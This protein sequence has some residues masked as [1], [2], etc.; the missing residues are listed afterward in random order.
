[1]AERQKD[2]QYSSRTRQITDTMQREQHY[3]KILHQ[4][5]E[6][7]P[8]ARRKSDPWC[9]E[10]QKMACGG[11]YNVQHLIYQEKPYEKNYKDY[12]FGLSTMRDHWATGLADIRKTLAVKNGLALPKNESGFITHA[13]HRNPK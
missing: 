1:V 6:Q 5:L 2:V 3:R 10:A 7:I 4:L 8:Q 13:I 11:K 9:V 12:Q